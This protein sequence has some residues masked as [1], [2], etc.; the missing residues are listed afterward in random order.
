MSYVRIYVHAVWA[1]K[2]R[3]P[4]LVGKT[5]LELMNHIREYAKSKK[6]NID[7]VNGGDDHLHALISMDPDQSIGGIMNQIKGESAY[8]INK[9]SS[10]EGEFSWQ[11]EYWAVSVGE[12]QLTSVRNYIRDQEAHHNLHTFEDEK[13]E[14]LK[15]NGFEEQ[16]E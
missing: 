6:I 5:R 9:Q 11:R 15:E 8:W 3:F 13:R 1:T 4:T 16:N 2:Y 10:K 14:F 7:H 12:S